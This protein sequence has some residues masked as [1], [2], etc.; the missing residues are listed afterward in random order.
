M[1]SFEDRFQASEPAPAQ[2]IPIVPAIRDGSEFPLD[3]LGPKLKAVVLAMIDKT[4]APAGIC[5]NSALAAAALA[6]QPYVDIQLPTMEIVPS[7]LFMV[8]VGESGERKSSVDKLALRAVRER[9]KEM[10]ADSVQDS[11]R[12]AAEMAAWGAAKKKAL[13]GNR[14]RAEMA[15]DLRRLGAE[16]TAPPEPLLISD[17][18]TFQ[19]LQRLF[20]VAMPA[21]G[22][23]A[24]EGGQFLGGHS[25]QEDNRGA[26]AAGL[27]KLWD[28]APIKRVRGADAMT[29]FLPGRRLSL[30]LMLQEVFARKLFG[31]PM[32]RS[33]GFLSRIL[34][35]SPKS[36]K[37]TRFWRD[38]DANSD[39]EIERYN[40]RIYKLLTDQMPMD[41]E[42]RE[43]K[44]RVITFT[45][46]ART[47]WI[48]FADAV[49]ADLKPEGKYAE[50][51]GFA[52]KLPEHAAR[53]A[54]VISMIQD[55]TVTEITDR[56]LAGAIALAMFYGEEALR[57]IG[58]GSAE[59]DSEN[60]ADLIAWIRKKELRVVGKRY[61]S[62]NVFPRS[63]RTAA[64][65]SRAIAL[66]E[67]HG[68]LS[69]IKGGAAMDRDGKFYR[70]AYAVVADDGK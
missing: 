2:P 40:A 4:Q 9:E 22:L 13:T 69:P 16:P 42:T 47:M 61:L 51:S 8:T 44:P 36:N 59:A 49:E 5:A 41:P 57:V 10:R 25:M 46:D 68:H 63:L 23:F 6:V 39:L 56:A 65:L 26:T 27:S 7:S 31:D 38:P 29:T 70:D 3:A 14:N 62:L 67:E 55:K 17:E 32:L 58:I 50:I 19:G 30:H 20:A 1:N 60:A 54:A 12:F 33:Q 48:A 64:T 43:L 45:A 52:A 28:G 53:I 18:P 24:D 34:I 11:V 35:C 37:G 66:L 15:E 21:L